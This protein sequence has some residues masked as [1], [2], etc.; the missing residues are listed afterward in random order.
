MKNWRSPALR[1]V[2]A[3]SQQ[4]EIGQIKQSC[5][6]V[7]IVRDSSPQ[8]SEPGRGRK[9][10]REDSGRGQFGSQGTVV[11]SFPEANHPEAH[12]GSPVADTGLKKSRHNGHDSE[13]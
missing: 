11:V 3:L 4:L 12:G 2:S 13:P 5:P 8:R 7:R 9:L 10:R 6:P 1:P